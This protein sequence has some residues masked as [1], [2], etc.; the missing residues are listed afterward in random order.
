LTLLSGPG[1]FHDTIGGLDG[2]GSGIPGS[3]AYTTTF[4]VAAST[5]ATLSM[6]DFIRGP[7]QAVNYAVGGTG[8]PLTLNHAAGITSLTFHVDYDPTLLT[9]TGILAGSIPAGDSLVADVTAPGHATFVFTAASALGSAPVTIGAIAASVPSSAVYGTRQ[10]LRLG[11][12]GVTGGAVFA[13]NALEVVGFLGDTDGN[14][15]YD[16]LDAPLVQ[17]VVV[18]LDSGFSA[19]PDVDPVIIAD[20]ARHGALV[21][22]DATRIGQEAATHARPEFPALPPTTITVDPTVLVVGQPPVAPAAVTTASGLVTSGAAAAF[23][24]DEDVMN[25]DSLRNRSIPM[26]IKLASV[27]ADFSLSNAPGGPEPWKKDFVTT[28]GAPADSARIRVVL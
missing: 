20:V 24:A 2:A 25:P 11:I 3:G 5:G 17:R 10:V 15:A 18:K 19:W 27:F 9:I 28:L 1:G 8:I 21:T 6:P 12:D 4:T 14:A 26:K 13:D 23:S 16:T 7:G 22:I